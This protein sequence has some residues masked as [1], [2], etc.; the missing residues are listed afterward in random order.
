MPSLKQIKKSMINLKISPEIISQI[1]LEAD[2]SGSNPLPVIAAIEKMDE[3]MTKEQK[4][5][6]MENQG[7]CKGGERDEACKAFN[8]A[9]EGEGLAERIEA[10]RAERL[11]KQGL[12]YIFPPTLNDDGSLTVSFG[13]HQNGVHTGRTTCSCST[14]KKLKQPF[15]VSSTYCGCCAGHF[16][17][18]YQNA[19][20][21]KLR[22]KEIISS[23]LNTNGEQPCT[24]NFEVVKVSK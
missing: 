11:Q 5:A 15:C 3:L 6:V 24:F 18:H 8:K 19:L 16:M 12:Y 1:P 2:T 14:I 9:H 23:P 4:Y 22:L 21:V 10:L 13:G 7:C 20:G 17:Y